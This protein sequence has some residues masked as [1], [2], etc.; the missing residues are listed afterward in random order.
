MP[1]QEYPPGTACSMAAGCGT[2]SHERS[3]D[4]RASMFSIR[5]TLTIEPDLG[6]LKELRGPG[7]YAE[8]RLSL[9]RSTRRGRCTALGGGGNIKF[10][11]EKAV[12]KITF[13]DILHS[14]IQS[15]SSAFAKDDFVI[16][17]PC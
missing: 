17:F 5:F 2:E 8:R 12:C 7:T 15:S 13:S 3:P 11:A 16:Y 6:V 14:G 4:E 10:R 1:V 9:G